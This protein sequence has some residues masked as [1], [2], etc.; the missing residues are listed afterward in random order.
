MIAEEERLDEGT[1]PPGGPIVERNKLLPVMQ[2][3]KRTGG[4]GFGEPVG[5]QERQIEVTI[6]EAAFGD[7]GFVELVNTDGDEFDLR[8]W[9]VGFEE[10]GFFSEG[11]FKIRIIAENDAQAVHAASKRAREN[12]GSFVRSTF[13]MR[14]VYRPAAAAVYRCQC[15]E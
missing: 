4:V 1:R 10:S 11:V 9:M 5:Y 6:A 2:V 12:S 14:F 7:C 8:P 3:L 15:D 13:M